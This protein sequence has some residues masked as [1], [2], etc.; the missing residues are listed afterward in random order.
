MR[1]R[2]GANIGTRGAEEREA[3]YELRIA[4]GLDQ[5]DFA[6]ALGV[7]TWR[8]A[9]IE[10]GKSVWKG[11]A[12]VEAVEALTAFLEERLDRHNENLAAFLS[13]PARFA[14][15]AAGRRMP[16]I[17]RGGSQTSRAGAEGALQGSVANCRPAAAE[18]QTA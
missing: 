14:V 13:N 12:Y 3:F 4:L 18:V 9:N 7:P 2:R 6:R 5:K 17:R 15:R 8:I 10:K 1:I 16:Q 11:V